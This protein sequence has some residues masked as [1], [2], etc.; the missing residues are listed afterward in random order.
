MAHSAF[1]AVWTETSEIFGTHDFSDVALGAFWTDLAEALF[2]VWARGN[3][4][5]WVDVEVQAIRGLRAE[6]VFGV[7]EAF[8]HFSKIV[9]MQEFAGIA[10]FT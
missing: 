3:F 1:R 8:G 2:V 4:G 9:L 7:K 5:H 10:L 6:T